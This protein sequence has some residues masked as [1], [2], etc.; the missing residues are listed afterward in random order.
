MKFCDL[1]KWPIIKKKTSNFGHRFI[2]CRLMLSPGLSTKLDS[3]NKP[4]Y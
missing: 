4:D 3:L 2:R 1:R